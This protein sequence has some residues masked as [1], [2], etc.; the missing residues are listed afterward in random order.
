MDN[1]K[2]WV[3]ETSK[4]INDQMQDFDMPEVKDY[5]NLTKDPE[6]YRKEILKFTSA[7]NEITRVYSKAGFFQSLLIEA[8]QDSTDIDC[9]GL[10]NATIKSIKTKC[11][12]LQ[13]QIDSLQTMI[14]SLRS[15]QSHSH[16][17]PNF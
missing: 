12:T 10:I 14:D 5:S 3:K 13:K 16:S 1:L 17:E 15:I 7:L 11:F 9:K 6:G 2:D 8:K 4:E